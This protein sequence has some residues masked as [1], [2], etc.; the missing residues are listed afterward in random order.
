MTC[1]DRRYILAIDE[2]TTNAK[3]LA[4]ADDGAIVARAA[5]PVDVAFPRP[6]W[7]EQDAEQLWRCALEAA[8]ECVAAA[9]GAAPAAIA[10]TNQRESVLVWDRATGRPEGPCITWQ[11]RRTA[12]ICDRL[13]AAGV[14]P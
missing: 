10:V 14:E 9:G 8:R 11:C 2:G 5:R 13:R 7:V 12:S 4:M 6:G 1:R 3:A